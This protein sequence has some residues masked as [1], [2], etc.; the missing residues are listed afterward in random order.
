MFGNFRRE[1][2][3]AAFGALWSCFWGTILCQDDRDVWGPNRDQA[4]LFGSW[5]GFILRICRASI[6]WSP[7]S[8]MCLHLLSWW[9]QSRISNRTIIVFIPHC[10][11]LPHAC[12]FEIFSTSTCAIRIVDECI[13]SSSLVPIPLPESQPLK[14]RI[15]PTILKSNP[16][17]QR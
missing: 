1:K 15:K 4:F 13:S 14:H 9:M 7:I 16:S 11:K 3:T 2:H 17:P 5:H 10:N 6:G 12:H 8:I